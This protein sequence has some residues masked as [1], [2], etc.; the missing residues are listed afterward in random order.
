MLCTGTYVYI[1]L[2]YAVSSKNTCLV[3]MM[4]EFPFFS[5]ESPRGRHDASSCK[6]LVWTAWLRRTSSHA[7]SASALMAALI[8]E[9]VSLRTGY[10]QV[11]AECDSR[12]SKYSMLTR[13]YQVP[14]TWYKA[15]RVSS[16]P[17]L[18]ATTTTTTDDVS[19]E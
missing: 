2:I 14:G 13:T 16:S 8:K 11:P 1:Y 5:L 4:V 7:A 15:T 9:R 12:V 10:N 17:K 19:C 6:D 18:S 3:L